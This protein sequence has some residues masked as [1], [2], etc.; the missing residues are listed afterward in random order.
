M[1]VAVRTETS[2]T[3]RSPRVAEALAAKLRTMIICGELAEGQ[4]LPPEGVLVG[5]FG[6]SRPTLRESLRILESEHLIVVRRGKHGGAQ[7]LTPAGSTAARQFG[8]LLQHRGTR[9][10]DV[11][12]STGMLEAHLVT[13]LARNRTPGNLE[14]LDTRLAAM[15]A[16]VNDAAAYSAAYLDFHRALVECFDNRAL[17]LCHEII[18]SVLAAANAD[19][20]RRHGDQTEAT[21]LE[22]QRVYTKLVALIRA[23]DVDGARRHWLRHMA[24]TTALMAADDTSVVELLS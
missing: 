4:V 2:E 3:T 17:T 22:A 6:V 16:A 23:Q 24:A 14:V 18:S 19:Q 20:V 5:Q 9:L 11:Y 21:R 13:E 7:V 1:A 15:H 8:L 12:D 10:R